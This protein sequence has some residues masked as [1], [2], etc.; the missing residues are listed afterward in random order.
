MNRFNRNFGYVNFGD[1]EEHVNSVKK[2]VPIIFGILILTGISGFQF[3]PMTVQTTEATTSKKIIGYFPEWESADVVNIDYSKLTHIIYFH[4]WPNPD[5]SLDT[6]AV[7]TNDLNTIR[8]NAHDVGVKV[9]ISAGGGGVSNGFSPMTSNDTSRASF[10]NNTVQFINE[11]DLDGV[12]INWEPLNTAAKKN[13]QAILLADL[14]TAL[15][16]KIVTVA[17][18]AERLDLYSSS[19]DDIDWANLLAYDMNW[20]HGEHSNFEDS[21]AA[22][23]RY[24][25]EGIPE[26]KLALGIPFYGRDL[27]TKAMKY[28]DIVITCNPLL[29]SEN[30]C[31]GY[32]FNGIDLVQQ[33]SQF[34]L[35][36]NYTGVM[37]WNLGQDTYDN[38][39]L[40]NA[41]YEVLDIPPPP[42]DGTCVPPP[43]DVWII[44]EDCE[45]SSD[46]IAFGSVLI[47]NNSLVAINSTGSLTIPA[48]ENITI[49]NNSG[50]LVLSGGKVIII[51]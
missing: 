35:N 18:N 10:V 12:D 49:E 1:R 38:T 16:D 27:Q 44:I 14:K 21:V 17:V 7:D 40:L 29:P 28:E 15:H 42:L 47:Q 8:E 46:I 6:S 3:L 26:E 37:I 5:G 34:V 9:L 19:A 23:E 22:L 4:I 36:S 39:S 31:D 45:I 41:I 25:A 11:Y 43:E 20:G 48:G 51:S 24:V 2:T 50:L 13:N 30:Y 32:F 33:K